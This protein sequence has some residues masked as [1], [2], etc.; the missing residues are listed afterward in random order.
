M[1]ASMDEEL[2]EQIRMFGECGDDRRHLYQIRPRSYDVDD[3]HIRLSVA[4][5]AFAPTEAARG[6]A[7]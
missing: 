6:G 5:I 3:L 2:R 4:R 1:L 7:D